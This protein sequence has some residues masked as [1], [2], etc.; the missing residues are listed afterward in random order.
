MASPPRSVPSITAT[1]PSSTSWLAQSIDASGEPSV[2]HLLTS[3]RPT[4]HAAELLVDVGLGDLVADPQ[5]GHREGPALA[6]D[7]ADPDRLAGRLGA[8]ARGG[9]VAERSSSTLPW[10]RRH[11]SRLQ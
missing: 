2:V 10:S 7:E 8:G 3:Q 11:P 6:V 1:T 5:L 9:G 4:L